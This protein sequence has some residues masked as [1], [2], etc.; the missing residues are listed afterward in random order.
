MNE[1]KLSCIDCTWADCKNFQK[2]NSIEIFFYITTKN[3]FSIRYNFHKEDFELWKKIIDYHTDEIE[4]II[5]KN[6]KK[7]I[8]SIENIKNEEIYYTFYL[9]SKDFNLYRNINLIFY[10]YYNEKDELEAM[11]SALKRNTIK[12]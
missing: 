8:I 6:D 9:N 10:T 1:Y 3:E 2:I 7:E 12:N 4:D 5:L 11:E